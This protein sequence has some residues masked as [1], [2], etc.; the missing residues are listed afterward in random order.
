MVSQVTIKEAPRLN[1]SPLIQV[2]PLA[3]DPNIV[4]PLKEFVAY[5]IE[6]VIEDLGQ[7]V[8]LYFLQLLVNLFELLLAL[9]VL[10][11]DAMF[12][13]E[14]RSQEFASSF[15]HAPYFLGSLE[16]VVDEIFHG[17]HAIS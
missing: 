9:I 14:D 1:I 12:S 3:Q 16:P 8:I 17:F 6:V 4:P 7:V 2:L 15:R 10:E 13:G 5:S 11:H